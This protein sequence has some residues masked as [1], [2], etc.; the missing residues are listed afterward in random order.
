MSERRVVVDVQALQSVAHA[1]RGIGRTVADHTSFLINAGAPIAACA[2]NPLLP[3]PPVLPPAIAARGNLVWG[4]ASVLR[5]IAAAGPFIYHLMS[6]YEDVR[7]SDALVARHTVGTADAL[8]VTF[9]DAIPYV[10]PETYQRSWSARQFLRRRAALLRAADLVLTISQSSARDAVQV[11]GVHE[12]RVVVIGSGAPEHF[13]REQPGDDPDAIIRRVAPTLRRPFLLSVSGDEPR[14]DPLGL[15][16][17]FA[18]LPPD[19]RRAH[20]L[21]IVCALRP[22]VVTVWQ[23]HARSV[24]L[25]PD[26]LVLTGFVDDDA[27]RAL[28]QR[29]RLFVFNSHCEGFGMPML[30][31]ARCGCPVITA[32]NSAIPEMLD[33]PASRFATGD[34]HNLTALMHRALIDDGLRATL[35]AAG[36]G[37]AARHTWE[38]TTRRTIEAYE[39]LDAS[40][41]RH[42]GR[43]RLAFVGPFPPA[44][45]GVADY[46]ERVVAAL[47]RSVDVDCFAE[48]DV[49]QVSCEPVAGVRRFPVD[50]LGRIFSPAGYDSVVYAIG[51]S[52]LHIK[53]F[54]RAL[55]YPGVVWLHD[56]CLAGLYLTRAGLYLPG[57]P[58]ERIDFD[59][60]RAQM[61][62]ALH[63]CM[64]DAAPDLGDDW[65][66][67]EAYVEA[68]AFMLEEVVHTARAIVVST[69]VARA[70]VLANCPEAPPVYVLPLAVP[71]RSAAPVAG[72]GTIWIVTLGVVSEVKRPDDLVRAFARVPSASSGVPAKLAI[73]GNVEPAYAEDLRALAVTLGVGD[74]VVVT[75]H[76]APDEYIAWAQRS[77]LVVQLRTRSI[78]EGSATVADALAD[79]KA[80][81]T[82]VGAAAEY[83]TGTVQYVDPTITVEELATRIG[84]L[85][86]D[87]D[88]RAALGEAA[89]RFAT[90]HTFDDVATAVLRILSEAHEPA[91]PYPID[92]AGSGVPVSSSIVSR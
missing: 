32:D 2:L 13:R 75:G 57:V 46:D 89:R 86:D 16:D 20:Q 42:R 39:R 9:Y 49:T 87:P 53:T 50:G 41:R 30:E 17:A 69:E 59:A 33:E 43:E 5:D 22:H 67:P 73:V 26:E 6:P 34:Q 47:Q 37:A 66:K 19:V 27:L 55:R 62:A 61:R 63:R 28:Y 78:G 10:M 36:D 68:G 8:V 71:A 81:I 82:S 90:A 44:T 74:A 14:K 79:G 70:T 23:E 12:D 52:R 60:A 77:S 92:Y 25:G 88:R 45:S 56:A 1:E 31:A 15:I 58:T 84:A 54:E 65:W 48:C 51:N 7:P 83:P 76:V 80:V 64:G 21:V 29:A 40:R 24:G 91:Y 18:A 72:D 3:V 4:S 11:L 38:A 35:V 85:L